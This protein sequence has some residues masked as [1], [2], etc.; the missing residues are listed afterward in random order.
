[1]ICAGSTEDLVVSCLDETQIRYVQC[2]VARTPQP[3]RHD[4]GEAGVD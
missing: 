3:S 4:G 1:M 2:I